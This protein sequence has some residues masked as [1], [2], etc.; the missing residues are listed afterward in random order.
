MLYIFNGD[1]ASHDMWY[2]I[3]QERNN[4]QWSEELFMIDLECF[5]RNNKG[6]F[7]LLIRESVLKARTI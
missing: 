6:M 5:T 2:F 4:I 3:R 1:L 7:K